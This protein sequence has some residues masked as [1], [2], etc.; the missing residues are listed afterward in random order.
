M[1]I[2]LEEVR[3]PTLNAFLDYW[4]GLRGNAFAPSWRSFDLMALPMEAIPRVIVADVLYGQDDRTPIDCIVRFWGTSHT[5][6]KG[7]DKT[8]KSVNSYPEFRG[9]R[10]YDEYLKVIAEKAPVASK[11]LVYLHSTTK[12]LTFGQTQVRVPLSNDGL[13]VDHV[14]SLV[15][16]ETFEFGDNSVARFDEKMFTKPVGQ[17]ARP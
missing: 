17:L 14:A 7:A 8:G 10:G 12:K 9:Q 2:E 1:F 13:R 11:D 5:I 16:W 3:Q 4:A 6:R 15:D